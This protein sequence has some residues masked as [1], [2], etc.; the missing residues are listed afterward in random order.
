VSGMGRREFVALLGGAAAAWPL[1]ARAQQPAMPVLGLLVAGTQA[2]FAPWVAAF[3]KG[4]VEAGFLEGRNVTI[5]YRWANNDNSRLQELATDLVRNRVAVIVTPAGTASALAAKAATTTIPIVF[6]AGTDPVVAGLV[7]SFNRPGGNVTGIH[8]MSSELGAKR[9]ALLHELRPEAAHFFLLVNPNNPLAAEAVTKDVTAA[10]ASIGRKIEALTAGSYRD[11]DTA[12]ASLAQ[13]RADALVVAAD[14]MFTSRRVQ[15]AT[16][17]ARHMLPAI[18]YLREFVDA[19]GLMSYGP[20]Q[21]K[22]FHQVGLYAGR[23]LK[24][25]KPADLPVMQATTFELVI[26]L[27]TARALGLEVPPTLLARADEVIE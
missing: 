19:G 24:G 18:Y 11:I 13:K 9:L 16:L 5:E 10:A 4:L 22:R 6:S 3:R 1:A 17:A 20:S 26:N 21:A 12:F 15:I 14:P 25:E 27:Q 7:A 23:I 2:E 8:Y